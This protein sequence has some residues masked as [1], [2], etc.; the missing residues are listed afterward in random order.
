MPELSF[1]PKQQEVLKSKANEILV[2]GAAGG[3]KIVALD[4]V[5]LTPF[6][7]E[8]GRDLK[9]GQTICHPNGGTQKIVQTHPVVTL[10]KWRVYFSDGTFTD[11]AGDHLW[12][13]WR[14]RKGIKKK[15]KRT[16][17]YESREV[18]ETQTLKKWLNAGYKPQIPVSREVAFNR[19]SREKNK[20]NHYLLGVLLGDGCLTAGN[21]TISCHEYDKEHYLNQFKG[22]ECN[23]VSR[24]TIRFT[25]KTNIRLIEKLKLHNLFKKYSHNKFIPEIYKLGSIDDRYSLIQGLMDTD[26]YSAVDKKACE[27]YTVSR[28]LADDTA[29][30][31]RSLGAVVTVNVKKTHY[32]KDNK[33]V[34][35]RPCYRLYIKHPEPDKLF[36][37]KRKKHGNFGENNISKA[38][39]KVEELNET[40]TGKCITVSNPDGLYITNDFIVTHN[41]WSLRAV[42]I[43]LASQI[44]KLQVYLLRRVSGDILANHFVGSGSFPEMLS[45]WIETGFCRIVYSPHA[46]IIFQNGSIIHCRHCQYESDK[47]KFQGVEIAVLLIDEAGH[48]TETIYQYLRGRCR[49]PEDREIKDALAEFN[50]KT[51]FSLKLPFILLSANPGGVG[52]HYLKQS[53]IDI[54]PPMQIKRM[55]DNDGGMLRQFIPAKLSDNPS[56]NQEEYKRQLQGLGNSELVRAMLEGDW[57]IAEG[58]FFGD[59]W[60]NSVHVVEPFPIPKSWH[61]D[62]GFDWGS[63]APFAVL[64]FA[65]SDGTDV[66]LK[67]GT[68]KTTKPGDVFIFA[69]LYGWNGK[70]NQ[71]LRL[72]AG[73][74]ARK[75]VNIEKHFPFRVKCGP[76]DSAIY[77][78]ENGNC[79]ADDM[80][81]QGIKWTRANKAP[82]SVELGCEAIRR[83]LKGALT[84]EDPGLYVFNTCRHT[85]RTLPVLPRDE[86]RPERYDSS[87][88]DHC[89]DTLRYRLLAK[90]TVKKNFSVT[91]I[92]G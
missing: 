8:K 11:V 77:T 49:V 9:V 16:F 26:G 13:A 45:D 30:V 82:G 89:A 4:G 29:F 88:E 10:P 91:G 5:V 38:V 19:I 42:A 31:L 50:K 33:K 25:G 64:W 52:H 54:Q 20:I 79:I 2:G 36:R 73:E 21:I 51:G 68:V 17:G 1:H 74:V 46:Q 66:Q 57:N 41:S 24:K 81:A 72:T 87:A 65:E 48:F 85:I 43:T 90:K 63:S 3:G 61:I 75:I 32:K 12:Q 86:R 58:A 76:A 53:F 67:D 70:P 69:E 56:L 35:C 47:Y 78:N 60:D 22:L 40:I 6:G 18:I 59:L 15:N 83:Y 71:G 28:Q 34:I 7:W 27:Y 37:L 39:V 23:S 80:A 44:P 55:P 14:G 92:G 62:R 84:R